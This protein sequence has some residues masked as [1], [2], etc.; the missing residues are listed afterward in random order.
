MAAVR[1]VDDFA[2]LTGE[3]GFRVPF[4]A[5]PAGRETTEL[6]G[7]VVMRFADV[8]AGGAIALLLECAPIIRA[9]TPEHE[10]VSRKG[11]FTLSLVMGCS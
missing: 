2:V 10:T 11:V 4:Q 9:R 1:A 8:S 3:P 5:S 6:C 7:Q